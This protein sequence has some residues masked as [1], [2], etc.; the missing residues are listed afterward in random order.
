MEEDQ[1]LGKLVEEENERINEEYKD[2]TNP[3]YVDPFEPVPLDRKAIDELIEWEQKL[4]TSIDPPPGVEEYL[5]PPSPGGQTDILTTARRFV[6]DIYPTI[7]GLVDYQLLRGRPVFTGILNALNPYVEVDNTGQISI[8]PLAIKGKQDIERI[9][10]SLLTYQMGR[11]R[12]LVSGGLPRI[13]DSVELTKQEVSPLT[14]RTVLNGINPGDGGRRSLM[15]VV[16]D[17]SDEE[18]STFLSD[19]NKYEQKEVFIAN[20]DPNDKQYKRKIAGHIPWSEVLNI[21]Q[22]HG[23]G[24]VEAWRYIK[25]QEDAFSKLKEVVSYINQ[26]ESSVLAPLIA[27]K[28]EELERDGTVKPGLLNK[29]RE[30]QRKASTTPGLTIH[31]LGH[32]ESLAELFSKHIGA[33][34]RATNTELETFINELVLTPDGQINQIGNA[35]RRDRSDLPIYTILKLKGTSID[36]EEDFLKF[37]F[38]EIFT[39]DAVPMDHRDTAVRQYSTLISDITTDYPELLR[40][41]NND[42]LEGIQRH[43]TY[44]LWE[45]YT[46]YGDQLSDARTE[47]MKKKIEKEWDQSIETI[48]ANIDEMMNNPEG[49][50][51]P[52]NRP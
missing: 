11:N 25:A 46:T 14:I 12:G 49:F 16:N 51:F 17:L 33:G 6:T 5:P 19:R 9:I 50:V 7:A 45:F 26:K 23:K 28:L 31:S 18:F 22:S 38:P 40:P 52:E 34:D 29:W 47:H 36:L 21:A 3:K 41:E 10:G 44:E 48:L 43:I 37:T 2:I 27:D 32:I 24:S 42:L 15:Q 13:T 20:L 8:N 39:N 35:G 1:E 30:L 4:E